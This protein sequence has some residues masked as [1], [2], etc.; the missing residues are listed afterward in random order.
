MVNREQLI[1]YLLHQM[2]ESDRDTMAERWFTEPD[3]REVLR[4][5]EAELLDGYA[6]G[7]I[8][9]EQ[10]KQVE[11]W[12]LAS[13]EQREKLDFARALATTFPN[14]SHRRAPWTALAAAAAVILLAALAF[15]T[16]RNRQLEAA[17]AAL[18]SQ[19]RAVQV[20]PFSG[21]VY[22]VYFP[23]GALRSGAGNSLRVPRGAAVVHLQ[24][25]LEESRRPFDAAVVSVA[26]HDLWRQQP[27][28]VEGTGE[29]A[30]ASL[31]IPAALLMTGDY[32]VKLESG[33]SP[34]TYFTFRVER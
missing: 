26:G 18:R 13:P 32:T 8:A 16:V 30:R 31:W 20:E 2:P 22:A 23:G 29:A 24:L 6:R 3:V 12:L 1:A 14:A 17:I 27:V 7:T 10:R 9:P 25:G 28:M 15:L 11:Q 4:A 21:G 5:V 19:S 33:S 34:A